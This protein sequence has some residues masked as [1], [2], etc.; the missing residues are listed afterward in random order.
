MSRCTSRGEHRSRNAC[1]SVLLLLLLFCDHSPGRL[2]SSLGRSPWKRR[3]GRQRTSS[4]KERYDT[5]TCCHKYLAMSPCLAIPLSCCCRDMS[6][7]SC[8][9]LTCQSRVIH[10]PNDKWLG[11]LPCCMASAQLEHGRFA[12]HGCIPRLCTA[13]IIASFCVLVCSRFSL[14]RAVL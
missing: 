6:S 9:T 12:A 13:T 3:P 8:S 7:R 14:L 11:L 4:N 5:S 1:C 10:L 2:Q